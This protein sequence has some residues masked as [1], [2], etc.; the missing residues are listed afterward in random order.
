MS[1]IINDIHTHTHTYIKYNMD[2]KFLNNLK[3]QLDCK[4]ETNL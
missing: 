4:T 3:T 1:Y 2:Q